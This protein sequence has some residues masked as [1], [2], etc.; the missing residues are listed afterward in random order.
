MRAGISDLNAMLRGQ[1]I[2]IVGLGG[3]GSYIL[4]L[5]A[6]TE[7]SEIHLIDADEFV[8]HNAFRAP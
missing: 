6:K 5:I 7:V 2:A 1:K 4:D 8:N 3:T